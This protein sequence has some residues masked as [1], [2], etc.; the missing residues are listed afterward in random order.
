MYFVQKA[1]EFQKAAKRKA[2][3]TEKEW[4]IAEQCARISEKLSL[5]KARD[6]R[7]GQNCRSYAL[8]ELQSSTK[9]K[10]KGY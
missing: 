7:K 6:W 1:D 4:R 3:E 8:K 5:R 10:I 9:G 2:T